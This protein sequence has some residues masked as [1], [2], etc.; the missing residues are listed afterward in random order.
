MERKG[1]GG[2]GRKVM[3]D[4]W[5]VGSGPTCLRDNSTPFLHLYAH[6]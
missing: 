1:M 3:G 4:S 5:I 6:E 2:Q